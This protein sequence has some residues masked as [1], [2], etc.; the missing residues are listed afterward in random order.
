MPF[1]SIF[2]NENF[3]AK[4]FNVNL[5]S[6]SPSVPS[7]VTFTLKKKFLS[8]RISLATVRLK[9]TVPVAPAAMLVQVAVSLLMVICG[10][11]QAMV[12]ESALLG[13]TPMFFNVTSISLFVEV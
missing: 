7:S 5:L 10:S 4:A 9:F 13:S 3:G 6:H 11:A 2:S 1:I 12:T 8:S